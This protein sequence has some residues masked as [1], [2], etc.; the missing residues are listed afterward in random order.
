MSKRKDFEDGLLEYGSKD[1]WDQFVKL[2][3]LRRKE[4]KPP[5]PLDPETEELKKKGYMP[6]LEG[7]I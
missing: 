4:L 7:I 2:E 6:E 3:A 5:S 1:Y